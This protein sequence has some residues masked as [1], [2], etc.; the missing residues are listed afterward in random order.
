[1]PLDWRWTAR[2]LAISAF[3]LF[4]LSAIS[5]WTLPACAIKDR[6]SEPYRYYVL[7]LGIW[8]WWAIFAPNPVRENQLLEAEVIDAKGLRH[9]HEFTKI[10]D[11]SWW[12]RIA[13]YRH[14]KFT[15]NMIQG[16]EYDRLREFAARHVV[17]QLGLGDDA[18]PLTVSLY[19]RV[20]DGPPPGSA[21]ADTMSP[22]R[23]QM[24]QR[25][26][27]ASLKEVRP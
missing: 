11:L 25:Y 18:F 2:R 14:P 5:I 6:F 1:V 27:F 9:I 19:V 12:E 8:Q 15:G 23:I 10:G 26:Q 17:R 21:V 4:H 24:I 3:V 7:P 13:R 22:A 20:T 16:G